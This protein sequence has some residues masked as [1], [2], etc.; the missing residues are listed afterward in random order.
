M[1]REELETFSGLKSIEFMAK[2]F[3]AKQWSIR[4]HAEFEDI[5][6]YDKKSL[7]IGTTEGG[8]PYEFNLQ[9]SS[10]MIAI[11]PTGCGKT[12]LEQGILSRFYAAGGLCAVPTD[13]KGEEYS[14]CKNPAQKFHWNKLLKYPLVTPADEKPIGLPIK[15]YY[16]YFFS[17]FVSRTFK[18][19]QYC[20]FGPTDLDMYDFLSMAGVESLEPLQRSAMEELFNKIRAGNVT[21]LKDMEEYLLKS[22]HITKNT[23]KLLVT[24]IRQLQEQEVVGSQ[25]PIPDFVN[26]L[27]KENPSIPVLNTYGSLTAGKKINSYIAAYI[28]IILRNIYHAKAR[29]EIPRRK[30]LMLILDEINRFAPSIGNP[31][32]K[33]AILDLLR[34]S[35]S[36]KISMFFSCQYIT[37]VPDILIDQA[38]HI[39]IPGKRMNTETVRSIMQQFA[40]WENDNPLV[41]MQSIALRQSQM[42]EWSWFCLDKKRG[43]TV[44][45]TPALP[46]CFH[47]I[48]SR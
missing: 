16:P 4:Q 26:D 11:A 36:E 5:T 22:H 15:A 1:G 31:S 3:K 40:P 46:L 2:E 42:K 7:A 47:K 43:E 19:Q 44:M 25:F 35:R 13:I 9:K 27:K 8:E 6:T 45:F 37:D 30:H 21:N 23:S 17:K 28:A 39:F 24:T 32:S 14:S 33:V 48:E 41:M 29:G 38:T 20:Q 18:D 10:K 12:V 34:L